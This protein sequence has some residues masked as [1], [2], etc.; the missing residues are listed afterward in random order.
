MAINGHRFLLL[1]ASAYKLAWGTLQQ[2]L[3]IVTAAIN[4]LFEI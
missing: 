4:A 3:V 1:A 2:H